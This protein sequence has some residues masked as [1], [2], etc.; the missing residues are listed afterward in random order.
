MEVEYQAATFAAVSVGSEGTD[1]I[2]LT[3]IST[4]K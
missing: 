1:L 2:N 3:A 4:L